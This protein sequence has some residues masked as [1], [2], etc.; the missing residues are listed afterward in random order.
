MSLYRTIGPLV[1]CV[2]FVC[3]DFC[4]VVVLVVF[5]FVLFFI[6]FF[7]FQLQST[8]P[9]HPV[10]LYEN[11]LIRIAMNINKT[12]KVAYWLSSKREGGVRSSLWVP[13]CVLEQDTFIPKI[14]LI[15]PR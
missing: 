15:I 12:S 1:I 3:F 11:C 6:Y 8:K 5:F 10:I 9:F 13:C 7:K 14:V 4:F 2:L